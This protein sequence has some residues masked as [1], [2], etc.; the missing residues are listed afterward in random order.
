MKTKM[1]ENSK[2]GILNKAEKLL[3]RRKTK[4]C[5]Q[6][7]LVEINLT[8]QYASVRIFFGER[9]SFVALKYTTF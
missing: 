2:G 7:I 6:N 4:V 1:A 5:P 8:F 3:R 9:K